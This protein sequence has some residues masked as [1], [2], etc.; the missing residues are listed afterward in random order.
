MNKHKRKKKENS[1][2]MQSIETLF[3]HVH[4]VQSAIACSP[5]SSLSTIL[6]YEMRSLLGEKMRTK[7]AHCLAYGPCCLAWSVLSDMFPASP[8]LPFDVSLV[9]P[10]KNEERGTFFSLFLSY[11][12]SSFMSWLVRVPVFFP[13]RENLFLLVCLFVS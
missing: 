12:V 2:P 3:P 9:Y 8:P 11:F 13:W 6:L 7:I 5:R 10:C 4:T 1:S